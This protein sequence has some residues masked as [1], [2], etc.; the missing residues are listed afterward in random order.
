MATSLRIATVAALLVL[1]PSDQAGAFFASGRIEV[2]VE[3]IANTVEGPVRSG[4]LLRE[5]V[6][7]YSKRD[8][9]LSVAEAR[10]HP[11]GGWE[12]TDRG[13]RCGSGPLEQPYSGSGPSVHPYLVAEPSTVARVVRQMQDERLLVVELSI[14]LRKLSGFEAGEAVYES[15]SVNRRLSF[16]ESHDAFVPLLVTSGSEGES[17]GI[18][19]VF[20]RVTASVARDESAAAYG[21]VLA[22]SGMTGA[23]LFLDRGVA[24]RIPADG[25]V[26]LRN[27]PAGLRDVRV[28][29]ASGHAIRKVV[30]VE[31]GRTSVVDLRAPDPQGPAAPYR[32]VPLGENAEGYEEYRRPADSAVVVKIPAGEFLMGNRETERTPLEHRVWVSDYLMDKTGVTWGRFKRFAEATRIPLPR[33]EPYW[34]IHDDHPMVYV[35]W[36]EAKSYCEWAGGRLPTEAER[37][38]AARGTDERMYPWGNEEPDKERAVFR[39]SWGFEPTDPVGTH[40]AGA[41]PYGVQDMGGSVWEW[42]ADWYDDGYYEVSP[43]RDPKGPDSGRA[44]AVRGGSWDSRPTVLSASCR[45]WGNR[46]YREGDF[47]FRCAMNAPD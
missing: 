19:E 15:S 36:E 35:S 28:L 18:R 34:G 46:G 16:S 31:P 47:G 42:C 40:P 12:T 9:W 37:E 5:E 39:R 29:D 30:R 3:V 25:R 38:K 11:S 22:T 10:P 17:S 26:A 33:H 44:H 23:D 32:L 20:V 21:V 45:S 2:S 13:I 8:W 24:G 27:V 43:Y 14:A 41:S 1:A 7:R 6:E 4:C